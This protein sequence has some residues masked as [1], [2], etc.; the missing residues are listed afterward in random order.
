MVF[1]L[2][3]GGPPRF[4]S[5]FV[6]GRVLQKPRGELPLMVRRPGSARAGLL[7]VWCMI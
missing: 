4:I 1:L 5:P 2:G 7:K 3:T 6:P